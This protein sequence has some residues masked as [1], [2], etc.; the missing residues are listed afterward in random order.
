MGILLYTFFVTILVFALGAK[1]PEPKK[2]KKPIHTS[3]AWFPAD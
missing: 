1:Y 2:A 3:M